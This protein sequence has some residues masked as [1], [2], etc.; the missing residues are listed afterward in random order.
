MRLASSRS[1]SNIEHM[2][3]SK[4]TDTDQVSE[5]DARKASVLRVLTFNI[6]DLPPIVK[7]IATRMNAIGQQL[8]TMH[9]DIVALQEAWNA[10]ARARIAQAAHLGG[11]AYTHYYQSGIAGSGLMLLS[12]FPI[13]E[14][15]FYRFPL[16][17]RREQF[18]ETDYFAGKGIGFARVLTPLGLMD[19]Y[20]THT[21]AS[22][23]AD[24]H[25]ENR[26]YRLADLYECV[27]FMNRSSAQPVICC[28]DF[29]TRR[30]QREYEIM[31]TLGRLRDA[32]RTLHP[33]DLGATF[34]PDNPYL[35]NVTAKCLDYV[36]VRDGTVTS[37]E[38][39]SAMVTL[40]TFQ[41]NA[42]A[43]P[44]AY[45][46][47]YAVLVELSVRE[48]VAP[49][50]SHTSDK[51]TRTKHVLLNLHAELQ[52]GLV[53]AR[54]RQMMNVLGTATG[55]AFLTIIHRAESGRRAVRVILRCAR[56]LA[57]IWTAGLA[58]ISLFA[59]PYEIHALLKL[60]DGIE[61]QLQAKRTFNGIA[62]EDE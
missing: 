56:L 11:L 53:S 33:S 21:V 29:N 45:S 43:P 13:V 16:G 57:A 34:A 49:T 1:A 27:R 55:L 12:R 26:P 37:L 44:I 2:D 28:G 17:G 41:P 24:E 30:E 48:T 31:P 9:L 19:V 54:R 3:S 5:L 52:R 58:G 62:W 50:V 46:D 42:S 39:V 36:F 38:P 22:Y 20:N 18:W 61:Q 59:V 4:V 14:T 35:P 60:M 7:D 10:A 8:A 23:T 51:G 40:R 6:W 32:Y 47:H 15:A 25:D